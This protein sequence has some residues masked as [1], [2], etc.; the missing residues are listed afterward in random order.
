MT[1]YDLR[2]FYIFALISNFPDGHPYHGQRG[3]S[4]MDEVFEEGLQGN[5]LRHET[6]VVLVPKVKIGLGFNIQEL[7]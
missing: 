3:V 5:L 6:H 2:L 1:W 7:R 4:G